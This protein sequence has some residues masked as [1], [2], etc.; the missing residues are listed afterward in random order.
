M[1][2]GRALAAAAFLFLLA[3]A[4]T[5]RAG[6]DF[7]LAPAAISGGGGV[8]AGGPF[9]LEG[10]VGQQDAGLMGGERFAILGGLWPMVSAV[11]LAPCAGD[12]GGDGR[13]V[14]D[15]LLT[16]VRLSLSGDA[17]NDCR[18]G[19][20]NDDGRVSV[21]EVIAAVGRALTSCF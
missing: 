1:N 18:P 16:M 3:A 9:T 20:G 10:T 2:P 13:V 11:T 4:A 14:V 8:S 5:A 7:E 6:G 19:D 21:D 12:C 15:E 17:P